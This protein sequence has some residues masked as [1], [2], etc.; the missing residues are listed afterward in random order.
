MYFTCCLFTSTGPRVVSNWRGS[1][2]SR[3]PRGGG[4]TPNRPPPP[5]STAATGSVQQLKYT[6]EFDFESANALFSK[7]QL[8]KEM[9]MKLKITEDQKEGGSDGGELTIREQEDMEEGELEREEEPR[10][11]GPSIEEEF[12]DKSKSFFDSISCESTQ[13]NNNR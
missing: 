9:K 3:P 8:E 5:S 12:Y 1:N 4:Y 13:P 10:G 7:D 11:D 2:Y 6:K